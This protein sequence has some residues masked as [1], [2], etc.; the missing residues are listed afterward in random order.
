MFTAEEESTSLAERNKMKL[1]VNEHMVLPKHIANLG[2]FS[3]RYR[4]LAPAST[5]HYYGYT[6][7]VGGVEWLSRD[8]FPLRTY[9]NQLYKLGRIQFKVD[10]FGPRG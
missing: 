2:D 3:V 10:K 5:P 4:N 7:V 6:H 8:S 1:K 9:E